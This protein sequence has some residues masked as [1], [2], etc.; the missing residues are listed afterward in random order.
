[1]GAAARPLGWADQSTKSGIDRL[2]V[3]KIFGNVGGKKN[4]ICASAITGKILARTP[5]NLAKSY[6]RR[7]SLR[8]VVLLIFFFIVFA[9]PLSGF[10]GR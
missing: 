2:F 7:S 4:E 10:Y 1:M 5:D 8:V 9:F 3:G 6:S